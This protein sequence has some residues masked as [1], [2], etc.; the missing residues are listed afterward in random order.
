MKCRKLTKRAFRKSLRFGA[1]VRGLFN[2]FMSLQNVLYV[3]TNIDVEY[4]ILQGKI[5]IIKKEGKDNAR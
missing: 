1:F 3:A 5:R 4:D 2:S